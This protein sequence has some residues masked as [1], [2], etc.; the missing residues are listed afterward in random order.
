MAITYLIQLS[1]PRGLRWVWTA[2]FVAVAGSTV[3][4][5]CWVTV[6][7]FGIPVARSINTGFRL[8]RTAP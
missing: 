5:G 8:L 3:P 1:T 4:G 7:D 6:R 2:L